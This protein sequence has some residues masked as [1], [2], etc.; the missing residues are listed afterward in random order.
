VGIHADHGPAQGSAQLTSCLLACRGQ[1]D[2]LDRP[3]R[4]VVEQAGGLGDQFG[5]G[6]IDL[7]GPEGGERAG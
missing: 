6:E 1:H 2:V 5:A 3:C 7:S 4:I